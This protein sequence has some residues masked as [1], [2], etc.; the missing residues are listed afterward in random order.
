MVARLVLGQR[1]AGEFGLW[2]SKPG[3]DVFSASGESLL[4]GPDY[5][6][7]KPILVG[8]LQTSGQIPHN[9]GYVPLALVFGDKAVTSQNTFKVSVNVRVNDLDI[10]N[11]NNR[12][13]SYVIWEVRAL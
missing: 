7:A 13:L 5:Y 1:N 9:L 10:T 12:L 8:S 4:F 11:T 6:N 2:V 3:V